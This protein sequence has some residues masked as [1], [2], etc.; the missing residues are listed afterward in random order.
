V[1]NLLYPQQS[2]NPTVERYD[3]PMN[4]YNQLTAEF[5][6]IATNYRLTEHYLSGPMSRFDS[7][8]NELQPAMF[9][10]ISPE[11][12]EEKGIEHG[13]WMVAWNSRGAIEARA[14]VTRRIQ[15]LF[16]N[17]RTVHQVGMPFHWG[18]SGETVGGIANDLT[19]IS[20]DP[21]V[22]MHEAKAITLNVR[23]GRLQSPEEWEPLPAALWPTRELAPDTP[24]SD[25]P[26]GQAI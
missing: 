26:E 3:V 9:I 16:V 1:P 12:A 5:P 24:K 25:Q 22:S 14:M 17:G 4:S 15:P 13:G 21:N 7:W 10:E 2:V 20:A 18:F 8:L 23:A 6:I 11:L 19:A